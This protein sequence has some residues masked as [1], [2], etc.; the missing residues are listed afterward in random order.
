MFLPSILTTF[1]SATLRFCSVSPSGHPKIY[2]PNDMQELPAEFRVGL[3]STIFELN[4]GINENRDS[5]NENR[6]CIFEN[7]AAIRD[8]AR[9]VDHLIE[10]AVNYYRYEPPSTPPDCE[11]NPTATSDEAQRERIAELEAKV[12]ELAAK[13]EDLTY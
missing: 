7:R 13:L 3:S 5:I 1:S 11:D 10:W 4:D 9:Q 6:D 8:L 12:A 2:L